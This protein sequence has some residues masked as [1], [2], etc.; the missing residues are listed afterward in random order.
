MKTILITGASSGFGKL[1]AK[2]LIEL[3]YT[4]YGAARRVNKMDDLVKMGGHALKIDVTSDESVKAAVAQVIEE[5]G[6]I[7]VLVNNAGYGAFST[8]EDISPKELK[9]QFDVNV[10]GYARLQ[11][12]VLPYMR[13]Q[14]SGR[15]ILLSSMS[16]K[17]SIACSGWYS[18]TKFAVEAMADALQMEVRHLGI[19]VVKIRPG[20]IKTDFHDVAFEKFNKVKLARD[21]D[22]LRQQFFAMMKKDFARSRTPETTIKSI[23]KAIETKKPKASYTTTSDA[24]QNLFLRNLLGEKLFEKAVLLIMKNTKYKDN[25]GIA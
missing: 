20:V 12:A 14:K 11:K 8:I 6:R 16:G 7:D 2:R 3:G 13:K 17:M 22:T 1:T 24:R 10:F 4:V 5:Q 18:A 25:V 15:I 19:K 9:Y 23:I 21:Y